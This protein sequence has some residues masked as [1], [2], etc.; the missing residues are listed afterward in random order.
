L[1]DWVKNNKEK[2]LL[3][4]LVL[5]SLWP[6]ST[7][8]FLP[9]WDN[10]DCYLPYRNFV[11]YAVHSGEWPFWNPFQHMG[12]PAY[13]DMQNGMY[14]PFVWLLLLFG[15]YNTTSLIIE[16]L[17]YY[18]IAIWGAYKFAGL[19]VSSNTT[20]TFI[21]VAY[22]LSGFMLG[23]SQIMIFIAGA[24]FLPL[25]LYHFLQL[26]S[27]KKLLDVLY[28]VLFL[29]LC[30]TSA[31]PAYTIVLIYILGVIFA[32]HLLKQLRFDK[33]VRNS[34]NW[35]QL[36]L[37]AL[38]LVCVLLPYINSVYEFLPYFNRANKLNYSSFLLENPF[39]LHEY[40]SF[41]FPYT[42]LADSA[43]FGNTDMTMRSA[44]I[45]LLPLIFLV[46]SLKFRKETKV[47]WLWIGALIFLIL[48]AGGTT[49]LYRFFYELPGFGLFRHPSLFRAHAL[50]FAVVLAGI[51]FERWDSTSNKKEIR[52][53]LIG[54]LSL[55]IAVF[56]FVLIKP[57]GDDLKTFFS[58][59]DPSTQPIRHYI[60]TYLL[61][62]TA[63]ML[64][65]I[66]LAIRK[67]NVGGN[68][69]Q[70]FV[71][72]LIVDLV[73]YSQVT[74]RYTIHYPMKNKEYVAYFQE[75][76]KEIDQSS[77]LKPYKQLN[78][79]YE[80]IIEGLW[81]NTAT[82]HR[83]L[84]FDGH[85]QTQF[86]HFNEIEQNGGLEMTK[87][88]PLFYDVN[89]HITLRKNS[90][91][92]PNVI[93]QSDEKKSIDINPDSLLI[94]NPQIKIN[95]F[96]VQVKNQSNKPDLLILNQNFHH[97]WKATINGKETPIIRANDAL[98]SIAIPPNSSNNIVYTFNSPKTKWAFYI[99]LLGYLTLFIGILFLSFKKESGSTV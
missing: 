3:T 56:A 50:L 14:N 34:S 31:S 77:A 2:L 48:C 79:G 74:S 64:P 98:M 58:N 55:F 78:E 4:F 42:T 87:E 57:H 35:K 60:K 39:D 18:V 24:A 15:E 90:P 19:F 16:L 20:K 47:K 25:I 75:L 23:T 1:I 53:L 67:I 36:V 66:I 33:S 80:P 96:T 40:I 26:L 65:L 45:G 41:L 68:V 49:P 54:V 97:L 84:S 93:W 62:N 73:I 13:S 94:S 10:I 46:Y 38:L 63:L 81:R 92:E 9:K 82:F 72:L 32:V 61:I 95:S 30:I 6:L 12:Y 27:T 37:L 28:T 71:I 29:A 17:F 86:I 5:L 70:Y 7:F 99:S 51:A 22:G 11:G 43:W 83:S 21:A 89:K 76:P 85:N 88:N 52:L 8:T 91:L 44:Y 59:L 69:K